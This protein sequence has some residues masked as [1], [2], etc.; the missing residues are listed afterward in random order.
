MY[1]VKNYSPIQSDLAKPGICLDDLLIMLVPFLAGYPKENVF[2]D[3]EHLHAGGIYLLE[4]YLKMRNQL[5]SLT[6]VLC[7]PL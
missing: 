7:I 2:N 6:P 4:I 3:E 5:C 1:A